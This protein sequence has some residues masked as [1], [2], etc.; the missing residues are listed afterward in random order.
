[1][2]GRGGEDETLF[3]FPAVWCC[4]CLHVFL[5]FS[6][7]SIKSIRYG[8]TDIVDNIRTHTH[9]HT[10]TYTRMQIIYPYPNDHRRNI[11]YPLCTHPL[12][13]NFGRRSVGRSVACRS[14]VSYALASINLLFH[15]LP[16]PQFS[17]LKKTFLTFYCLFLIILKTGKTLW[18]RNFAQEKN[19]GNIF[20]ICILVQSHLLTPPP[21]LLFNL[22][23]IFANFHNFAILICVNCH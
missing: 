12:E 20:N 1:M 6:S 21:L 11:C 18:C 14:S 17:D 22:I 4:I 16:P 8:L 9:T 10:Y 3:Q 5:S 23:Q 7:S 13:I 15:N 2:V 19:G